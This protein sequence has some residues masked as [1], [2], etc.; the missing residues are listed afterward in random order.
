MRLVSVVTSTRSSRST[1]RLISESRS[2][3]WVRGRAD[4]DLRVD[5][6]GRPHDLLDHAAG[7]A[8]ARSRRGV[9]ETKIVCGAS[10]SN[11][12]KRSGRLSSADGRRKPYSTS[13]SLRERS[14]RYMPPSC[15]HGHVAL[16]D[17]QQG[18]VGQVVE[19]ASAAARR[20]R[21]PER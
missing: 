1:R 15:G 5:Q 4:L 11:S 8:R 18:I 10:A 14:P 12:S 7:S 2:S 3:T 21:A 6:P 13:V 17:E 9:A 19:Q 20:R 16:V